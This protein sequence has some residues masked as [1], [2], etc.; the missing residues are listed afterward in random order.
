MAVFKCKMCGG[1]LEVSEGMTV[2]KCEYCGTQQTL[3]KTDNEQNLN[4]FNRANHFRQQCE[5][6]KAAEIYEKMAARS[7][8]DAELYWSIVLCRYG[9]EYVDDPLTK[10]KIATCHR[11]QFK[12]ILNDPDYLSALE[13]AD[14]MQRSVYEREAAYIDSVQKGILEISN[15][16]QP[17]DVFICYKE[18]DEK[19]RRTQDSVLAQE[20][21]YG[22]T[23]EG[24]KVFFSRITLESKLGTQYEPYIFAALNSA[25]VMVVV[26]TK[27]EFFNAVWVRNEWS[28]YLML[29]Q[30]DRSRTLI[31][32]YKDMDPYDLPDALSMFQAQDMSRLGFMQD[33]IRGIKKII[34]KEPEKPVVQQPVIQNTP[35]V[36]IAALLKRTALFLE[37]RNWKSAQEYCEKVLDQDPENA[38]AY[39]YKLMAELTIAK[40]DELQNCADPFDNRDNFKKAVRFGDD[41]LKTKLNGF[42]S[43]IKERNEKK[44][45]D[46]LYR[47]TVNSMRNA[48][49]HSEYMKVEQAFREIEDYLDS[50]EL[51]DQCAEKGEE[52]RKNELY[53]NATQLIR[54]DSI[55]SLQNALEQLRQIPDYMDSEQLIQKTEKRLDE[56]QTA[57]AEADKRAQYEAEQQKLCDDEI[58]KIYVRVN[59]FS[60]TDDFKMLKQIHDKAELKARERNECS[61][62]KRAIIICIIFIIGIFFGAFAEKAGNGPYLSSTNLRMF[63]SSLVGGFGLEALC[64]WFL[65]IDRVLDWFDNFIARIF[66]AAVVFVPIVVGFA[67]ARYIVKFMDTGLFNLF[68]SLESSSLKQFLV[69]IAVFSVIIFFVAIRPLLRKKQLNQQYEALVSEYNKMFKGY[70][71]KEKTELGIVYE[72]YKNFNYNSKMDSLNKTLDQYSYS[73]VH[74]IISKLNKEGEEQ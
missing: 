68:P 17:F 7:D 10:K 22:L 48:R 25:K 41:Q 32:A 60:S 39:L 71:E 62:N 30:E 58:H 26:G 27:P 64:L 28:R 42:S 65:A 55:D 59:S 53:Q 35:T 9:I 5:F 6:D 40:V 11:T 16:E 37:D 74:N 13:H 1:A 24:F 51:A 4:M 38:W 36:N 44:R 19:G 3:P 47:S 21:Y 50:K 31:P 49:N 46:L 67:G 18:T 70:C 8:G 14:T 63:S 2:C 45:I 52:A 29:M 33:L 34:R 72:K 54:K 61:G 69:V 57:K 20:L 23:Q 66:G 15:K 56:L 73:S 43:Q 12:S